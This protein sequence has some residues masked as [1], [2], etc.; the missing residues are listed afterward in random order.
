MPVPLAAVR[1]L[2][3]GAALEDVEEISTQQ[4]KEVLFKRVLAVLP[5]QM[6]TVVL[7]AITLVL[8]VVVPVE[9]ETATR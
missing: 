2:A 4:R 1:M 8:P 7:A 9:M 3:T 6:V 5:V